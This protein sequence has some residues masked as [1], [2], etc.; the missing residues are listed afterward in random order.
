MGGW[1]NREERDKIKEKRKEEDIHPF[2]YNTFQS[3]RI[4]SSHND[5]RI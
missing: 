2:L 3:R 5:S 4:H 1:E